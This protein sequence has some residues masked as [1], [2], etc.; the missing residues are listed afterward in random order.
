MYFKLQNRLYNLRSSI[1][2]FGSENIK[3]VHYGLQHVKYICQKL[4]ELVPNNIKC[5]NS[6]SHIN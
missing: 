6:L 3:T 1:H 2:Q 4:W 5:N